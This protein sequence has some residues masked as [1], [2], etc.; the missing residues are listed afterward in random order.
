MS[1]FHSNAVLLASIEHET[2]CEQCNSKKGELRL[3]WLTVG[4][5]NLFDDEH[6]EPL[7]N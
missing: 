1:S 7:T 3:L 5:F 2:V 6:L 4:K